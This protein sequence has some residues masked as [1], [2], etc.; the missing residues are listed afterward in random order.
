VIFSQ[1]MKTPKDSAEH[2][3]KKLFF[4][5]LL[6]VYGRKPVVEAL[7]QT[8]LPCFRLHL[9]ESNK[10]SAIIAEI[11][12]LA[13][14]RDIEIHYHD[15]LALSRISKNG[16]QDQGV[17]LDI[18]CPDHQDYTSFLDKRKK[19]GGNKS[20]RLLALDRITNPQNLGMIIRSCCAGNIDGLLL[21]E[22]GCAKLDALVTKAST[23]TVFRAPILHCESLSKA[24]HQ[25]RQEGAIVV[26]LSSHAKQTLQQFVEG[27]FVIYVLGNESAGMSTEIESLCQQK[28]KIPM[29]NAVESLNVAVTSSLLAFRHML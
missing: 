6:T 20:I 7:G 15:R 8:D 10:P 23:G 1:N 12:Q 22:K 5:Q 18:S 26:G 19:N 11:E 3:E 4:K 17:C 27:D 2:I 9:A 13:K 28:I 29:N 21:S 24:L 25:C 16:K 14:K